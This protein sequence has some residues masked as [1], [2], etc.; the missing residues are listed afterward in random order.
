MDMVTIAISIIIG[1]ISLIVTL[2]SCTWIIAKRFSDTEKE[3]VR[4]TEALSSLARRIERVEYK[5]DIEN[6]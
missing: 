5:M 1:V 4:L 2:I 3:I 6:G